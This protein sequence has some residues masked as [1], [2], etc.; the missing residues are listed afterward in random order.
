MKVKLLSVLILFVLQLGSCCD[1][2]DEI[3]TQNNTINGIWYLKNV[4]GGFVGIN[5]DYLYGDVKWVFNP[6]G[7]L[8]VQNNIT[9]SGPESI[10]A[11]LESGTYS[12]RVVQN[13]NIQTLLIENVEKGNITIKNNTLKIDECVTSDGFLMEF[14]R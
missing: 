4:S 2:T 3:Q 13:G 5:I 8:I 7:I 12:Y 10:Y 11:G 14:I 9:T 6:N 1:D